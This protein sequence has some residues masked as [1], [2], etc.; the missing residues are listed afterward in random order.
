MGEGHGKYAS[1]VFP[2]ELVAVELV[3]AVVLTVF[4]VVW[5]TPRPSSLVLDAET[6]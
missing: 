5:G 3:T 6:C 4:V 1:V 2:V